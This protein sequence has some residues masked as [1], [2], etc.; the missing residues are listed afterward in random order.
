LVFSPMV[1]PKLILPS[2]NFS[3]FILLSEPKQTIWR[4]PLPG[5]VGIV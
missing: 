1:V 2:P 3:I 5:N 4:Q